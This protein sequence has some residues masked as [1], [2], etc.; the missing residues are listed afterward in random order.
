MENNQT[1]EIR[2]PITEEERK[3]LDE[4]LWEVLWKP[5]NLHREIRTDLKITGREIEL[6]A[7]NQGKCIGGLVGVIINEGESEIRHIAV[8]SS[9]QCQN[10]GGKLIDKY[11][12]VMK[13]ENVRRVKTYAR[14]TSEPFFTKQGF[15]RIGEKLVHQDFIKHDIFFYEM[16]YLD[17]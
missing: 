12:N 9:N 15:I 1:I 8:K 17:K 5:I 4:L 11:K 16:E 2:K 7:V 6:I 3:D 14:N 10:I 13:K